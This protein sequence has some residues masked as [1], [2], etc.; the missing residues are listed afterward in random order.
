MT[1]RAKADKGKIDKKAHLKTLEE[2][3]IS[4]PEKPPLPSDPEALAKAIFEVVDW[5]FDKSK[6]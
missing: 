1:E 6:K 3:D 4:N 2:V 5:Q